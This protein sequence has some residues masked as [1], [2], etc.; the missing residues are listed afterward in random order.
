MFK[1]TVKIVRHCSVCEATY[2]VTTIMIFG[3]KFQWTKQ[4]TY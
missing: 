1:Y 2:R 4:L 3:L